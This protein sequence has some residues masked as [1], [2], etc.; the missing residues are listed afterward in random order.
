MRSRVG[1]LAVVA[2]A[3]VVVWRRGEVARVLTRSTG[4]WTG[5]PSWPGGRA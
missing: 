1:Y 2:A 4:T 3:V 5:R